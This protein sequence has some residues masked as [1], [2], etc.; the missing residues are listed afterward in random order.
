[1]FL[2]LWM[3]CCTAAGWAWIPRPRAP[4]PSRSSKGLQETTETSHQRT[5][6]AEVVTSYTRQTRSQTR[7]IS[8]LSNPPPLETL[9]DLTLEQQTMKPPIGKSSMSEASQWAFLCYV[10]L[11][12][13]KKNTITATNLR[14]CRT[15]T[16]SQSVQ[17]TLQLKGYSSV[18]LIHG[19][20][21]S[22]T[23]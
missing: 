6:S 21:H 1:M 16:W 12:A 17:V 22:D 7:D 10:K 3:G 11:F 9:N 4:A 15:S 19:L 5:I 20:K 14:R 2:Y 8:R 23:E 18:S 13:D